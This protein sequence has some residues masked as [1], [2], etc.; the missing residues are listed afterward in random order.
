MTS[1][2]SAGDA[3]ALTFRTAEVGPNPW[4][5]PDPIGQRIVLTSVACILVAVL[6]FGPHRVW[7]A[8]AMAIIQTA[9]TIAVKRRDLSITDELERLEELRASGIIDDDE[10]RAAKHKLLS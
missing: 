6:P 7:F 8:V 9:W 2:E 1:I 10:F 3:P 5:R 4:Q